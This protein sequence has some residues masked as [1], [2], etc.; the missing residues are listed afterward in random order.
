MCL[1]CATYKLQPGHGGQMVQLGL[2]MGPHHACVCG[3][4]KS[5]T[6]K[7]SQETMVNHNE[8]AVIYCMESDPV[9]DTTRDT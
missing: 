9:C 5:F 4:A 6:K 3:W 1:T 7:L 2:N 8:D